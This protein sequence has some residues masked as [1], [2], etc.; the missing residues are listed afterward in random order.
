MHVDSRFAS[1]V[2]LVGFLTFIGCTTGDGD[3][4]T[5]PPPP[6]ENHAPDITIASGPADS[7]NASDAADFTWRGTDQDG[8]LAGY[9]AGLDGNFIWTTDTTASY[10]NFNAGESH[11]FRVVAEDSADA[12]SDTAE[13]AFGIYALLPDVIL[14]AYGEGITD[15]DADGFWIQFN[16]RLIP[17]VM[18]GSA[19]NLR[20]IIGLQPTYGGSEIIDSTDLVTRSPGQDDTLTYTLPTVTKNY[21]DVRLELHGA[22][23][24]M[25]VDIPYDSI[26]SLTQIGL[27]DLDGFFAWFDDAWTANAVDT[28]PG[29][30]P[31]GYYESIDLW[32]DVDAYP[33]AGFVKV[34]VYERSSVEDSLVTDHYFYGTTLHE[35]EGFGGEDAFGIKITAGLTFDEYDYRLELRDQ[36]DMLIDVIDYG[37]DPD[38]MDI[39]LGR[40]G[41]LHL[42]PEVSLELHK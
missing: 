36:E 21:Y 8:N 34:V 22:D 39:P 27:E 33:D 26:G 16:V 29:G 41:S 1:F 6:P 38:L 40:P 17:Q 2:V 37:D 28:L 13:W 30:N 31:D 24:S 4:G 5:G 23:G 12:L 7:I 10:S 18:T 9:Y 32:W 3:N 35:I 15:E 20:L 19:L 25:L 42:K 11:L 14:T